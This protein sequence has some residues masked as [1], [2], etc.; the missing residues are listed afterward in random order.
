MILI[1]N[2]PKMEIG[3]SGRERLTVWKMNFSKICPSTKFCLP[4]S[5]YLYNITLRQLRHIYFYQYQ[6]IFLQK[7]LLKN[8]QFMLNEL[9]WTMKEWSA[10][11]VFLY[12]VYAVA[13]NKMLLQ[14]HLENKFSLQTIPR[15]AASI[16]TL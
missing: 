7:S 4:F 16:F 1:V 5:P 15:A 11:E 8:F 9:F 6:E 3:L 2:H 14:I 13:S 12:N 10:I